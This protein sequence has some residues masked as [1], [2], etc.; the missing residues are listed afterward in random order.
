LATG[1]AVF[2]L[3]V[4]FALVVGIWVLTSLIGLL[5][6]LL[7]AGLIGWLADQIV[8]GRIPYGW[9]GAIVAGLLGS[10][11]GGILLGEVGPTIGGISIIPALIGAIILAFVLE[12]IG[13]TQSTT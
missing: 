5:I 10:F 3:V 8:P 12:A 13:K 11:I 9:L 7:I 6:T 2:L 4:F 1:C